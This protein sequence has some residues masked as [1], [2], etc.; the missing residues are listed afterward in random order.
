MACLPG[1]KKK[2]GIIIIIKNI[3]TMKS[4]QAISHTKHANGRQLKL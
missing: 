3:K 4:S 2:K 1:K